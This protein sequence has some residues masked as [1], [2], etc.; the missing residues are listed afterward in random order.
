MKNNP[1]KRFKFFKPR[2]FV[3]LK[4]VILPKDEDDEEQDRDQDPAVDT[5]IEKGEDD[6][7]KNDEI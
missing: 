5:Q 3:P 1:K 2:A 6:G 7:S 4:D